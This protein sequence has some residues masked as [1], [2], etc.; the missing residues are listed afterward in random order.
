MIKN[1]FTKHQLHLD[2]IGSICTHEAPAMLGNC[3]GFAALP[4]KGIPN[5]KYIHCFLHPHALG[6][7]TLRPDLRKTL[8]ISVKVVNMIRGR[9]L[10][11]QQFQSFCEE[12]GKEHTVLLYHTEVRWLSRGRVLSRLFEM[13]DEI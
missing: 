12:V 6:A 11:H 2:R 4:R 8:E 9:A 3:S 13:R 1:F 7:K 5:L 10:N